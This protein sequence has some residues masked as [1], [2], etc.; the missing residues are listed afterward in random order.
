MPSASRRWW[1]H[2]TNPTPAAKKTGVDA[3]MA[4]RIADV[5]KAFTKIRIGNGENI[6]FGVNRSDPT[7][8]VSL[9]FERRKPP[10]SGTGQ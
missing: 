5:R 10:E 9:P 7:I 6:S 2:G 3:P 4:R 1:R 8:L